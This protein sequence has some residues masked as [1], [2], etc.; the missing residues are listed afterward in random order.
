[1]LPISGVVGSVMLML[2]GTSQVL[3]SQQPESIDKEFISAL[4][5]PTAQIFLKASATDIAQRSSGNCDRIRAASNGLGL[6]LSAAEIEKLGANYSIFINSSR[7]AAIHNLLVSY[8]G[9]GNYKTSRMNGREG[10]F[11]FFDPQQSSLPHDSSTVQVVQKAKS[12]ANINLMHKVSV[13]ELTDFVAQSR[14]GSIGF[15][16]NFRGRTCWIIVN[17]RGMNLCYGPC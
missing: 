3:Y 14:S 8:A 4:R 5:S 11:W 13:S 7:L 16:Y 17:L 6:G 1:M 12:I 9:E 15:A 10:Q 2:V